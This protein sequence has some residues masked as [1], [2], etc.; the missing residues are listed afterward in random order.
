MHEQV[1]TVVP[2]LKFAIV[3]TMAMLGV[4]APGARS[5]RLRKDC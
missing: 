5:T 1:P 3:G 2:Y 4:V